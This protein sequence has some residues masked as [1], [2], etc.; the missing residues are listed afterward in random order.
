[1]VQ[2]GMQRSKSIEF[3]DWDTSF[4]EKKPGISCQSCQP[5]VRN[6]HCSN[7]AAVLPAL[8]CNVTMARTSVPTAQPATTGQGA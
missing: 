6:L 8:A 2:Y 1:M 7:Y 5:V 3:F 4:A